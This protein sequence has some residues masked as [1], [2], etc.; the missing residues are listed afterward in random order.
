MAKISEKNQNM[1]DRSVEFKDKLSKI[2]VCVFDVDGILTEG[3]IIYS[4]GLQSYNRIF[5]IL[6][7]YG[8]K[9]LMDN[10]IKVGIISGGDSKSVRMRFTDNLKVDF[11]FLGHLDKRA[12]YLEVLK[13]GY[14]DEEVLFMGD[15]FIDLPILKRVGFSVSV[16]HASVEIQ[17]AVDYITQNEG[18]RGAVREMCDILRFAQNLNSEVEGF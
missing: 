16:P 5:N 7:G 3:S 13:M 18:G 9:I 10:G 17:Q 8:L 2:K 4:E 11:C 15:E 6:D 14:T 12:S 1:L